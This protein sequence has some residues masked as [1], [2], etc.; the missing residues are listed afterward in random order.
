[1]KGVIR[2][3]FVVL[4]ITVL[5]FFGKNYL[6]TKSDNE[7]VAARPQVCL[8]MIV[9]N[10]KDV[11]V[12]CLESTL[13]LIDTWVIVDTGSTDGTQEI[14][15]EFMKKKKVPGKLF[16]RPWINFEHNRNEALDLGKKEGNYV[17]F[18]DA[19]E[20]FVYEPGFKRPILDKDFY[21]VSLDAS[22]WEYSRVTLLNTSLDSKWA[23]V[24]HEA[25]VLPPSAT[26]STLKHVKNV[27]THDGARSKD[28]QKFAKDAAL[29]EEALKKEPNNTRYRFY[30]AQSYKDAGEL[31]LALTNYETRANMGGWDQ[32]VFFSYLQMALIQEAL[33]KPSETIMDS[34][35]KAIQARNTRVEPYYYMAEH[36]RKKEDYK[37]AYLIAKVA[38]SMPKSDDVLFVHKW[39]HD[40][41]AKLEMS[42]NAY[43]VGNYE[44]CLEIC[45][46]LLGRNDLPDN[47]RTCVLHN[48]AWAVGRLV[49]LSNN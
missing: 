3:A 18:I 33:N 22:G 24:L 45:Q 10:E 32:E 7:K 5:Y 38:A 43:W 46:E 14:I 37:T 2:C 8:N 25:L 16:E 27:I 4:I 13:P 19:D 29:L 47:V 31:E 30:L 11:I 17:L 21:Y 15:Q 42:I 12:R 49:I 41:G 23:G 36:L 9:K 40:Y 28:P 20:F 35:S 34:Y 44:E 48:Q 1:M 26:N 6:D 39:I